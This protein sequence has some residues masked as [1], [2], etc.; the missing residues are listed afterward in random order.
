M[1]LIQILLSLI[2]LAL[3]FIC[4]CLR[5]VLRET[6]AEKNKAVPKKG[7]CFTP[8]CNGTASFGNGEIGYFCE[9][10]WKNIDRDP[11]GFKRTVDETKET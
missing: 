1:N 10:C 11:I 7:S 6:L 5:K 2:V 4:C 9:A 3:C 8:D